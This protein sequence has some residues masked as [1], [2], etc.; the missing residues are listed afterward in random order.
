MPVPP[1]VNVVAED[2]PGE[3]RLPLNVAV[4]EPATFTVRLVAPLARVRLPVKVRSPVP[5]ASPKVMAPPA[6]FRLTD[7]ENDR[8]EA[9][10]AAKTVPVDVLL[11]AM[12]AFVPAAEAELTRVVPALTTKLPVNGLVAFRI[13]VPAPALVTPSLPEIGAVIVSVR[14]AVPTVM[15]GDPVETSRVNT[16]LLVWEMVMSVV[17]ELWVIFPIVRFVFT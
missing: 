16:E 11:L 4:V 1:L 3:S 13:S 9:P 17:V 8:A 10:V 15:V 6:V 12:V 5:V 14:A 2:A 7:F